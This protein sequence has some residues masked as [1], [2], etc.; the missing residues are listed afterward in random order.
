MLSPN[1]VGKTKGV[2]AGLEAKK[3]GIEQ[4]NSVRTISVLLPTGLLINACLLAVRDSISPVI[5]MVLQI[6]AIILMVAGLVLTVKQR[7]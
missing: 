5:H 4:E 2:I 6:F 3:T 7:E 1:A